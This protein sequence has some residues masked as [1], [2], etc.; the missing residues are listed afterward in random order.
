MVATLDSVTKVST[1]LCCPE[2]GS[3]C[4]IWELPPGKYAHWS[5]HAMAGS[6]YY[7]VN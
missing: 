3:W 5:D 2:R 1:G 7:L 6:W 4:T